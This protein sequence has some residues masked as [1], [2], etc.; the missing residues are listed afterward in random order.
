MGKGARLVQPN[1]GT[2]LNAA[3]SAVN[4]PVATY[5]LERRHAPLNTETATGE[6]AISPACGANENIVRLPQD[7]QN[8]QT[9]RAAFVRYLLRKGARVNNKRGQSPALTA[10]LWCE[11]IARVLLG[12]GANPNTRDDARMTPLMHVVA[13]DDCDRDLAVALLAA[14][15]NVNLQNEMGRTALMYAAEAGDVAFLRLLLSHEANRDLRD[16]AGKTALDLAQAGG[17]A[18]A[19]QVL[20]NAT[21]NVKP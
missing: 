14:G 2:A 15:A 8:Y 6:T 3:C 19:S 17:S 12:A 7:A 20:A 1:G 4:Q 13:G 16:K 9:R 11:P 10:S 21:K 18:E 5:L